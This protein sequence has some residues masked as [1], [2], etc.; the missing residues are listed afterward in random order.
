MS[1]P[2]VV[3]RAATED[4]APAC[5]DLWVAAV[6]VRDGV[7]ESEAVRQRAAAKFTVP[8]VAL[9]VAVDDDGPGG[10][11]LVT[12]PGTG[13]TGDPGDA[14]YLALLAVDPRVQGRGLGRSLLRAAVDAAGRAGHH[15]CLL[16]ALDDNAPALRLYR[17]AGF[18]P[19]GAAFPHALSGRPTR[20]WVTSASGGRPPRPAT[21][22]TSP[23]ARSA[24]TAAATGS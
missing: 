13:F 5:V 23:G 17:S 10:F 3:V 11:A 20:A 6:A 18:Q 22:P 16:H 15:R 19:V 1:E 2:S 21:A 14:A 9:I 7:R 24:G 12:G 8:R 4:E